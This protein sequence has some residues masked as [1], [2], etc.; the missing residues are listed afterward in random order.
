[1]PN[2]DYLEPF[3]RGIRTENEETCPAWAHEVWEAHEFDVLECKERS[4]F[5]QCLREREIEL[6]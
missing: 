6:P 5:E 2:L 4:D 1:M 3:C